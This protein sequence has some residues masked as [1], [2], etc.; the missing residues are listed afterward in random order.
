MCALEYMWVYVR[1]FWF[2]KCDLVRQKY[3]NV[4]QNM[5][6]YNIEIPLARSGIAWRRGNEREYNKAPTHYPRQNSSTND[7][8]SGKDAG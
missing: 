8:V 3:N 7:F 1:V 6:Q 4:V 2:W 5:S